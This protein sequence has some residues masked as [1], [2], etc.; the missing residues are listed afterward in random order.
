MNY[1]KINQQKDNNNKY[2]NNNTNFH[3]THKWEG[4]MSEKCIIIIRMVTVNLY[5]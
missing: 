2:Q 3:S 5:V 1:T 4:K